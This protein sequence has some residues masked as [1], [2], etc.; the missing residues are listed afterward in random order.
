MEAEI[1]G[2]RTESFGEIGCFSFYPGKNL[3]AFGDA[4]AVVTNSPELVAEKVRLLRNYGQ[5]SKEPA[6]LAGVQQPARYAA[7]VRLVV[8]DAAYRA[9]DGAA[10]PR[11][12]GLVP[13]SVG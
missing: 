9:L 6:R 1:G 10:A 5:P 13:R 11:R 2:Q 3:G 7:G 4:G 8:Q 12:G